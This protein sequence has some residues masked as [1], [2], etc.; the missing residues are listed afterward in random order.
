MYVALY[1]LVLEFT[2]TNAVPKAFNSST[3]SQ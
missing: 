3:L 2:G 1:F